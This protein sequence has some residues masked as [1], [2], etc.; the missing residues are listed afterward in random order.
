[1]IRGKIN[2]GPEVIVLTGPESTGKTTLARQLAGHYGG[3]WI[4]E[5]ARSYV[6]NLTVPYTYADV[7]HIARH[8]I[9]VP[10]QIINSKM[11]VVF[12]DTD[13]IIIKVWLSVVYGKVPEWLHKAI[14]NRKI[15]L[16]LLCRPDIAWVPDPARENPG[17]KREEL[18]LMYEKEIKK[19][20][21][22]YGMVSGSGDKRFFNAVNL[23]DKILRNRREGEK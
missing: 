11:P 17:R 23:V 4:P 6:E 5:Y 18:F 16:Y 7:I 21:F 15:D 10:E 1:M 8:Q 9:E 3:Q 12:L 2:K 14:T 13:L 22:R 19:Y 20:N